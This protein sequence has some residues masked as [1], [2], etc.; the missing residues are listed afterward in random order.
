M[1]L[2]NGDCIEQMQK[3]KDEGKQIDSVV[4]DPPYHLTSIVERYGKD[5]SAPAKDKD[6]LYQRQARGFM[7][8]E[9]DGGDI[10]FRTDTWKLAYDLL[11]P[12]GYLLA[13]SASRNY[14]R[15]AVAIEDA[16][17]E[18]RDQI[19]WIYGSGFPKSLN[20][21]KA[22]DK[23]LG[24]ERE[25][26]G[27]R[28]SAFGDADGSE[29]DDGRNLWGKESTKEVELTKGNSEYEG[30]GTALKPAH[31]PI[32]MARKPLEGTNIDNVLKYGT[33]AINIDGCRIETNPEVDDMLRE[34]ERVQRDEKN[35]WSNKNSG[36]KNENNNLTG[37]RKEGRYPANVMHD[38]SDVVQEIF[39]QTSKSVSTKRT[40]K[41]IGSFGMPNDTTPEYDDEG[42]AARYFYCPKT[43]AEERNRGL[44][45]F[46][47]KPMA[48]G[49][50]AKAELKRGN[51]D[52]KGN[53]GDGSKHN[54]V[55]MRLN[56]HPTVKPQEL[57]KYLCRLVTPKGGVVL[58]PF[59]GSG[60]TGMAAK[61]EGFDFIGIEKEKEYFEI[62]EARIKVSS[63]LMEFM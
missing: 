36:F 17:F 18:I 15:M 2:L 11:K 42:T 47:A 31:E 9:W 63:P 53:Q 6:G 1:L 24:N 23:R 10:A 38:G 29:T 35:V 58:D 34:V 8:K 27:T 62:A 33:G 12:G 25:V 48:W 26:V 7:G 46:T 14:H 28:V 44:E 50:Q 60:S 43:S 3:L 49:N 32:V 51:L 57:M 56:T 61:D 52:F 41:T 13:F 59:M 22:I 55:A 45:S 20:I 54:K 4:T 16:G 37:V 19:M 40:R 21:G 5:G 30:W 39:P